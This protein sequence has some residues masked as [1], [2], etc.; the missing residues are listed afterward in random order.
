MVQL[1]RRRATRIHKHYRHKYRLVYSGKILWGR[2]W[3]NAYSTD[4]TIPLTGLYL[5]NKQVHRYTKRYVQGSSNQYS[6]LAKNLKQLNCSLTA[7]ETVVYLLNMIVHMMTTNEL[8][9]HVTM[10]PWMQSKSQ[11][12]MKINCD[13]SSIKFK[14]KGRGKIQSVKVRIVV[15]F[16]RRWWLQGWNSWFA[17]ALEQLK[18]EFIALHRASWKALCQRQW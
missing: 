10:D 11:S 7:E 3:I 6:L 17:G 9:P 2:S 18:Y 4:P 13:F 8:Q 1:E 12:Q 16:G 15:I 5:T 14:K